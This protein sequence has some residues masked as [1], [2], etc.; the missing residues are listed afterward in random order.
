[1]IPHLRA[2]NDIINIAPNIFASCSND[3]TICIWNNVTFR[4]INTFGGHR[5][6]I[7]NLLLLPD[8]RLV[9]SSN[10]NTI[11]IRGSVI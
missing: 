8:G 3:R 10:D 7:N 9:S 4:K 6:F 2:I 11:R 1:M 5:G